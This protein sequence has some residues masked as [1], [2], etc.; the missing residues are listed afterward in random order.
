MPNPTASEINSAQW[1]NETHTAALLETSRSGAVLVQTINGDYSGGWRVAFNEWLALGNTP[2]PFVP[3]SRRL[4][5]VREFINRISDAKQS[6]VITYAFRVGASGELLR[7][8][9][10]WW[11]IRC[12]AASNIDL[13]APITI[14]GIDSLVTEGILTTDEKAALLA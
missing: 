14:N 7:P 13:D 2:L 8:Q 3:M 1:A 9:A 5:S 4:I 11:L 10:A 6:A 12:L